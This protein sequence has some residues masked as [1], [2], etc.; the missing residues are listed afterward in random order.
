MRPV[1]DDEKG[2]NV[3]TGERKKETRIRT[4]GRRIVRID[5]EREKERERERGKASAEEASK[6]THGRT[7]LVWL[8][9]V[10]VAGAWANKRGLST[11]VRLCAGRFEGEVAS[12]AVNSG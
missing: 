5:D 10:A 8:E 11:W 7:G 9:K 3:G 4:S 2:S 6:Q 12:C 1:D